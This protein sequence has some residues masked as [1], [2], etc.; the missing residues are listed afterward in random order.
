LFT[1]FKSKTRRLFLDPNKGEAVEISKGEK[2]DIILSPSLY[3]VKKMKLPVTTVR[4]VKKLLP[5]IFEETLPSS[6][7]SYTAYKKGDEFFVFAYED[8]KIFELLHKKGISVTHIHSV[9][10]AQTEFMTLE[11][12]VKINETQ[13]MYLKDDILLLAP[14]VW[15]SE[16]KNLELENLKLSKERIK[17]QQFG[18]IVDNGSL[19]KIG[20]VMVI[21]ALILMVEIYIASSKRDAVLASKD[22]LFSKYGLQPTM[23]QNKSTFSKYSKIYETQMRLRE[24]ISYFLTMKLKSGQKIL[25]LDYK[26]KILSVTV[27]GVKKGAS[28]TFFSQLDAK[29]LKYKSSFHGENVKVEIKL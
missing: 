25:L 6:H 7:Y 10:F 26:N 9:H 18:H 17:L 2:L 23:M 29:K 20:A 21:L 11:D 28:R 19:Y 12:A 3:W 14:L 15:M 16:T 13:A 4:E 5:S 24:Y 27:S 1:K 8:K 22:A